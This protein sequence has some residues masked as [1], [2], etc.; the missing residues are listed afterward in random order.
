MKNDMDDLFKYLFIK[1]YIEEDNPKNS[2]DNETDE[3]DND[4][5][6]IQK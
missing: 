5:N 6:S 3:S 1:E 4:E 2:E